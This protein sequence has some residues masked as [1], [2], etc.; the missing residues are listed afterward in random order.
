MTTLTDG[1]VI[2]Y[3]LKKITVKEYKTIFEPSERGE[4]YAILARVAGLKPE[5]FEELTIY[6]TKLL[7]KGFFDA[8]KEPLTNP[9]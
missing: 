8:I 9:T 3:D 1:R 2:D 6:D 4:D 7:W 5:E